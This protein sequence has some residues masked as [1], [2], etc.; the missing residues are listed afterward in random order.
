MTKKAPRGHILAGLFVVLALSAN[1]ARSR[2]VTRLCFVIVA[3]EKRGKGGQNND[4]RHDENEH[5]HVDS[6]HLALPWLAQ[7]LFNI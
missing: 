1:N 2:I 6:G 3:D 5:A 4:R 7:Q